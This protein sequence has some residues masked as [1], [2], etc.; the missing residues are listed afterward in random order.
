MIVTAMAT[1]LILLGTGTPETSPDRASAAL[2][3]RHG[4]TVL[5]FDAGRAAVLRLAQAGIDVTDVDALFISHRHSDHVTS[6]NDLALA[7]W[8]ELTRLSV[9]RP[10]PIYAPRGDAASVIRRLLDAFEEEVGEAAP[11]QRPSDVL[12]RIV[13][14]E[15]GDE[16]RVVWD[17]D[18]VRVSAVS[19]P[20]GPAAVA[21]RIDTA[22]GAIV[23]SGDTP[24]CESVER[25]SR[26]STVLVHEVFRAEIFKDTAVRQRGLGVHAGAVELGAMA[27]RAGVPTLIL[28]H[29]LPVPREQR[30]LDGFAGDVRKGGYSGDLVLGSDLLRWVIG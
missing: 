4:T 28:T 14:F 17:G 20:H 22:D 26:G 10:L 16:P 13:E 24:V 11:D 23:Y 8:F 21:F 27:Q 12:A 29:Y 7:H 30:H 6:V 18:G 3:V 2:V 1:E 9:A 5:Q 19:V 25:L 15:H